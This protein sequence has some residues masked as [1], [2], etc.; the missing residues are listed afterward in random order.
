MT[1]DEPTLLWTV[2]DY[3][4]RS[5]D[6]NPRVRAWAMERLQQQHPLHALE[7]AVEALG[8][9]DQYTRFFA[10]EILR[11]WGDASFAPGVLA[12]LAAARSNELA[13]RAR[14]LTDWRCEDA[15]EPLV[16]HMKGQSIDLEEL[17]G[18]CYAFSQLVPEELSP[19][20][21][22]QP[23]EAETDLLGQQTMVDG[24]ALCHLEADIAWL[25][26][27]WIDEP[28]YGR[29][30]H[31]IMKALRGAGGPDWLAENLPDTF[32]KGAAAVTARIEKDE[33]VRLPLTDP[34]LD[35]VL[36]S[37]RAGEGAWARTLLATARAMVE[38]RQLPLE[39]WRDADERPDGYRWQVLA[40]NSLLEHLVSIEDRLPKLEAEQQRTLLALALAGLAGILADQDDLAWLDSRGDDRREA[41]LELLGSPRDRLPLQVEREL[42]ALGPSI[43]PRLRRQLA[44]G[45]DYWARARASRIIERI[46][47]YHPE[48]CLDLVED[49]LD[50]I[51]RDE[52]DYIHEPAYRTLRLLGPPA[53]PAV[54]RRLRETEDE[55]GELSDVLACYPIPRTAEIL[56]E[57]LL[58]EPEGTR[59][60]RSSVVSLACEDS[61]AFLFE[62]GFAEIDDEHWAQAMLDLCAVHGVSHPHA[63][64]W[65]A[66]VEQ[67]EAARQARRDR[68]WGLTPQRPA[69]RGVGGGSTATP[70][71]SGSADELRKKR[72]AKRQQRKKA[73]GKKGKKKR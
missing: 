71:K 17:G 41:L 45:E 32:A 12:G 46:A 57:L 18:L 70:K 11:R 14:L 50:A 72:K 30:G 65:R 29:I 47:A 36:R 9:E 19:W 63:P 73:R 60:I 27:R 35:E 43:L 23:D 53:A 16:A 4:D 61:I 64:R 55:Y 6:P 42:A 67:A 54:E 59:E 66:L 15:I 68:L 24:L 28:R 22:H 7:R 8:D 26:D 56:H 44:A 20:V 25:V 52:G 39:A 33:R 69:S 34:E 21:K 38:E 1:T 31:A 48:S 37:M 40:T 58:D 10:F 62:H 3:L 49:L 5:R 51:D 13:K 2:E